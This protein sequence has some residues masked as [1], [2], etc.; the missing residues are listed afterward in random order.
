MNTVE[1]KTNK[2]II[3]ANH[4]DLVQNWGESAQ[5]LSFNQVMDLMD[6]A[7]ENFAMARE[8]KTG[9]INA[10]KDAWEHVGRTITIEGKTGTMFD[11]VA[12][13]APSKE[14]DEL[15]I[16]LNKIG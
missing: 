9:D 4:K 16:R 7:V 1:R 10:R 5:L 14:Y 8:Y 15:M 6:A 12:E 11:G 13:T 3:N 2:E